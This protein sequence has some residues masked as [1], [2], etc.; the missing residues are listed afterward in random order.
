[1]KMNKVRL[2]SEASERLKHLKA[3]TGLTPNILCRLGFC[4]SLGEVSLPDPEVFPEDGS[5]FNR[6]TLTGEWDALFVA[7]LKQRCANGG[8]AS[9][10]GLEGQFRAHLNRGVLMLYKSCKDLSDLQRLLPKV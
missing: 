5:E 3:R 10:N 8:P 1:M 4:L 6:Y 2:C 9:P 7:L